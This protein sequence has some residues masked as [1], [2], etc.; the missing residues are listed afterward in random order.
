MLLQLAGK[1][2]ELPRQSTPVSQTSQAVQPSRRIPANEQDND[3][4]LEY[5]ANGPEGASGVSLRGASPAQLGLAV[6]VLLGT[7]SLATFAG[8]RRVSRKCKPNE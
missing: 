7:G 3:W 5:E 1:S 2:A 6:G 8:K 4:L